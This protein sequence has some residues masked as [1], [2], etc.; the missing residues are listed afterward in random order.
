M[1]EENLKKIEAGQVNGLRVVQALEVVMRC[2]HKELFD[3][4]TAEDTLSYFITL[5][6]Q[7]CRSRPS[8]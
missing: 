4:A 5:Q 2:G 7:S 6:C 3:I 8:Y 1:T